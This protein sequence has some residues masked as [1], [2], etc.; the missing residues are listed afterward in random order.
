MDLLD[1]RFK[2]QACI[3]NPLFGTTS[4]HAAALFS[5]LGEQE[6]KAFFDKF[7]ENGGKILSSNGEVPLFGTG[8]EFERA[9]AEIV[10]TWRNTLTYALG[11]GLTAALMGFLLGFTVGRRVRLR[12][13]CLGICVGLFSL[14]PTLAVLGI[15]QLS[16]EAPAWTDP[17]LRSRAT[18]CLV[19]GFRFFPAAAFLGLAGVGSHVFHLDLGWGNSWCFLN[20][21]LVEGSA[22]IHVSRARTVCPLGGTSGNR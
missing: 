3:A 12:M 18:I 22:S 6:A 8:M 16:A 21:I 14:P 17:L 11:A 5:I 13:L 19:Q 2:D 20:E 15:I 10:R 9:A 4:M 1:P 7:V